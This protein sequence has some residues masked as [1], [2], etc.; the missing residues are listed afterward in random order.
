MKAKGKSKSESHAAETG[1]SAGDA[2]IIRKQIFVI[3]SILAVAGAGYGVW[4]WGENNGWGNPERAVKIKMDR[5]NQ[6]FIDRDLD[7][8][9]KLYEAVI[10]RYPENAQKSQAMTQLGTAYEEK[11]ELAKAVATYQRLLKELEGQPKKDLRAYTLLQVAKLTGQQGDFKTALSL[12]EQV[13]K[14]HPGTD[15]AGEALSEIGKDWQEQHD[16]P[17]A[18]ATYNALIKEM[19]AGFLAAEAQASI[20]ACLE[21]E[22]KDHE[23]IRAYQ[24]VLDKYPSAVWDQAKSR[25]DVLKKR[26]EKNG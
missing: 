2:A 1:R 21:A 20:G 24:V 3:F 4:F 8:A 23:A 17:K 14:D 25:I 18:I 5:A 12:F 26:L 7:G 19:P 22:G 16:Y 6:A 9:V 13:R 15:W 10:D 11:G